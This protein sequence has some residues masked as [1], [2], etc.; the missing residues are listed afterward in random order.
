[1]LNLKVK[2]AKMLLRTAFL[3]ADPV[4]L[5]KGVKIGLHGTECN[6]STQSKKRFE[7][8]NGYIQEE[9]DHITMRHGLANQITDGVLDGESFATN[10][11]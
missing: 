11:W 5:L 2:A 9:S 3:L 10:F 7:S 6:L 4:T 8:N 1:M